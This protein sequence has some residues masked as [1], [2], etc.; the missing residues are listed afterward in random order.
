MIKERIL[1]NDTIYRL[2]F[3]GNAKEEMKELMV[4]TED[5]RDAFTKDEEQKESFNRL[6]GDANFVFSD[7]NDNSFVINKKGNVLQILKAY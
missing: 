3:L 7:L 5:F 2:E 1:I 4:T 6:T